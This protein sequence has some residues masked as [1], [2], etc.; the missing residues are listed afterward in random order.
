[1]LSARALQGEAR[2]LGGAF[3]PSTNNSAR[4]REP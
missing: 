3:L 4:A 2:L 1:V